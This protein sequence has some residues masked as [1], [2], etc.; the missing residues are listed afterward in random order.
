MTEESPNASSFRMHSS[1]FVKLNIS[2]HDNLQKDIYSLETLAQIALVF[3]VTRIL[4]GFRLPLR[5]S[6]LSENTAAEAV[7]NKFFSTH[8]PLALFLE[9]LSILISSSNVQVDVNRIAGVSNDLADALGPTMWP[10][11]HMQ[12]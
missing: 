4:P 1:D 9:R 8:M 3:L 5:T 10:A 7:S 12:P 11:M 2:M 6:T